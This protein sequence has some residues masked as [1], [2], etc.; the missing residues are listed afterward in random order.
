MYLK[1]FQEARSLKY[2]RI[3]FIILSDK[4]IW[5]MFLEGWGLHGVVALREW[6]TVHRVVDHMKFQGI[7]CRKYESQIMKMDEDSLFLMCSQSIPSK[8]GWFVKSLRPFL[9]SLSSAVQI[10]LFI[11][12]LAGFE[13]GGSSSLSGGKSNW[14]CRKKLFK[15]QNQDIKLINMHVVL[16]ITFFFFLLQAHQEVVL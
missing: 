9:P 6:F 12:S 16:L 8:K 5:K 7:N 13:T 4:I 15:D 2:E 1:R 3:F 10:R 14:F 11:K